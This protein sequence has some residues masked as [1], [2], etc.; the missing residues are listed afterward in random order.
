M[1]RAVRSRRR[2]AKWYYILSLMTQKS[3]KTQ[4]T[5][6]AARLKSSCHC[7]EEAGGARQLEVPCPDAFRHLVEA[8]HGRI[9]HFAQHAAPLVG[10]VS[11]KET[12]EDTRDADD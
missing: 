1:G 10:V 4:T 9:L 3:Q 7:R 6:P 2:T 5:V 11:A 12:R 8:E